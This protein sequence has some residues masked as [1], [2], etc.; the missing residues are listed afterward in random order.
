MPMFV[1]PM[2]RFAVGL[3]DPQET[4]VVDMCAYCGREIYRGTYAVDV[5]LS[6]L[7][8]SRNKKSAQ[9]L[10]NSNSDLMH[11]SCWDDCAWDFRLSEDEADVIASTV[12]V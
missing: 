3:P 12:E 8:A 11:L 6:A 9:A 7:P 10:N 2:D 4:P 1:M 5:N